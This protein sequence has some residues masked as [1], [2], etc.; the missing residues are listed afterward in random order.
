MKIVILRGG[1]WRTPRRDSPAN[2]ASIRERG[3]PFRVEGLAGLE[4][5]AIATAG[6]TP[7]HLAHGDAPRVDD[8][9]AL[10]VRDLATGQRVFCAPGLSQISGTAL[11]WMQGADCLLL[12]PMTAPDEPGHGDAYTAWLALLRDLPARHKVLFGEAPDDAG[13]AAWAAFGIATARAGMEIE[14]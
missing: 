4:F 11:E 10:A 1:A 9:I 3:A 13:Q 8:N 12:D 7:P 2:A 14:V 6:V 5:T